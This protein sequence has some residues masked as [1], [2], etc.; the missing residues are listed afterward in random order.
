MSGRYAGLIDFLL[1][2]EASEVT[3]SF[4]E[5]ESMVGTPLPASARR[6]QAYWSA[7]NHLGGLL[8]ESGWRASARFTD[9]RVRF[10]LTSSTAPE[11]HP[12]PDRSLEISVPQAPDIVLIGCVKTKRPGQHPAGL[13]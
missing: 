7:G 3:L 9:D 13:N 10:S 5:I 6:Y 1:R 12:A 11:R 2:Q 4:A 8:A